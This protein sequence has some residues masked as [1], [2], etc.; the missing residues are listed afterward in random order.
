MEPSRYLEYIRAEGAALGVAARTAPTAPV[1][2]CP[3][4]DMTGL[5]SH[6]GAIHHWVSK[7]VETRSADYV[8]GD[9]PPD[10]FDALMAWYEGGVASL[11]AALS[12]AGPAAAVWNWLDRGPAPARFWFRRMAIETAVH[13]WD[14]ENAAA[15]RQADPIASDLAIDGI[16]E[17]LEFVAVR[18]THQPIEGFEGTLH[19]HAIDTDG[20][21]SLELHENGLEVS[22]E[23]TKADAAIRG[24]TS[25]LFLWMVNRLEVDA[26]SLQPLGNPLVLASWRQLE[27]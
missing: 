4:W 18:L 2:T 11:V 3:E 5:V 19:L 20:E 22:H 23:H 27:F 17:Y 8:E 13:R 7:I 14:G 25:D 10:G 9:G 16:D 21:W 24:T 15:P 6:T 1:T 26:P 12:D